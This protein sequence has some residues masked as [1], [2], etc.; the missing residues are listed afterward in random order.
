MSADSRGDEDCCVAGDW[1]AFRAAN[2]GEIG[3]WASCAWRAENRG[4]SGADGDSKDDLREV[5]L[6]GTGEEDICGADV[7][8]RE[9]AAGFCSLE[10]EVEDGRSASGV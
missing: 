7:D 3:G 5:G 8:G 6:G 1:A 4:G 9:L 2:L 10:K